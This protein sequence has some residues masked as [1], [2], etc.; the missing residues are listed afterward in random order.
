MAKDADSIMACSLPDR[1]RE[2]RSVPHCYAVTFLSSQSPT[3]LRFIQ[4]SSILLR[5]EEG[6]R[7]I[8]CL[9]S[10]W[11]LVESLTADI[12]VLSHVLWG[13]TP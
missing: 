3:I 12:G 1:F 9:K 4:M 2:R 13:W 8:L 5:N 10:D 7:G 11:A 6:E